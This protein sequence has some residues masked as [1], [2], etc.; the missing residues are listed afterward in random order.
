[1]IF[2]FPVGTLIAIHVFS[3]IGKQWRTADGNAEAAV[4]A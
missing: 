3:Q 4:A 2:G 1:M